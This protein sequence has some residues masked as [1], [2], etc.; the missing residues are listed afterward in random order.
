MNKTDIENDFKQ[1]YGSGDVHTCFVPIPLM[2]M[3]GGCFSYGGSTLI[4]PMNAG[5]W[6]CG[7]INSHMNITI[8]TTADNVK[9][10]HPV[11]E[12]LSRNFRSSYELIFRL[13]QHFS[14]DS[15]ADFLFH[16]DIPECFCIDTEVACCTVAAI[17]MNELFGGGEKQDIPSL[18]A[19]FTVPEYKLLSYALMCA[20]K[21]HVVYIN[22]SDQTCEALP[23]MDS[24]QKLIVVYPSKKN[25]QKSPP[26]LRQA[27]PLPLN[28]IRLD[29][30]SDKNSVLYK[31]ALSSQNTQSACR[32]LKNNGIESFFSAFSEENLPNGCISKFISFTDNYF[33]YDNSVDSLLNEIN[34]NSKNA[35]SFIIT[36]CSS[37]AEIKTGMQS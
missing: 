20:R 27:P 31:L 3:G 34:T 32:I 12:N 24:T 7:R 13:A 4:I 9:L 25:M 1:R 17:M 22:G 36:G 14:A 19:D 29:T 33:A 26:V 30:I 23:L 16:C 6:L 28:D 15:G 21:N 35:S 18:I 11:Y 2:L 5:V 37:G 8:G 10:C